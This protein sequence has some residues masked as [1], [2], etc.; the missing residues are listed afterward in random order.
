MCSPT[1]SSSKPT[2]ATGTPPS[3]LG[4]SMLELREV[5]AAYG[6]V[7]AL[8]GVSLEVRAGEIV[9]LLGANGAGKSTTLRLVSGLRPPAP[10][11]RPLQRPPIPPRPP[12]TST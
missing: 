5:H 9:A 10:G 6:H 8:R 4:A 2:S 1:R 12:R 11:A 3:A 7:T